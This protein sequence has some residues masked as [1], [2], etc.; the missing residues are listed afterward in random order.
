LWREHGELRSLDELFANVERLLD[1]LG[2]LRAAGGHLQPIANDG[3]FAEFAAEF[4]SAGDLSCTCRSGPFSLH[5]GAELEFADT[6]DSNSGSVAV[7]AVEPTAD[8]QERNE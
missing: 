8:I 4:E 3:S 1:V 5:S 6:G 2:W 7:A